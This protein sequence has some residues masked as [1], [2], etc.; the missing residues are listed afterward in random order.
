MSG[1]YGG[2]KLLS[3]D[4]SREIS[5]DLWEDIPHCDF[6]VANPGSCYPE[7]VHTP[8]RYCRTSQSLLTKSAI[9]SGCPTAQSLPPELQQVYEWRIKPHAREQKGMKKKLNM[10]QNLCVLSPNNAFKYGY[11]PEEPTTAAGPMFVS[12]AK[13]VDLYIIY[14]MSFLVW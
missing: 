1:A 8:C 7:D 14:L 6:Y 10:K 11:T 2:G 5:G 4:Y 12:S 13:L 9:N 3:P